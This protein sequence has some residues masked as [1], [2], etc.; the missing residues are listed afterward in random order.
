MGIVDRRL[1]VITGKGGVGRST[2]T[3][4]LGLAAARR[5][6]RVALV[7]L[8]RQ[9][10]LPRM[11]AMG[12]RTYEPRRVAP[13]VDLLGLSTLDCL[14]DFGRRKLGLRN[15]AKWFFESSLMK[16]FVTAVPGLPDVIQLGKIE[17]MITQPLKNESAYDLVIVDGPA[18]GQGLTLLDSARA[19][20]DVTR[21]GPFYDLA[22]R[23]ADFLSD[24][25]QTATLAVTLPESL[26][27]SETLQLDQ[28]MR[29][30][31]HQLHGVLLNRWPR[32]HLPST[33]T[34]DA[35]AASLDAATGLSADG[36]ASLRTLATRHLAHLDAA[37]QVRE[38]LAEGLASGLPIVD[39]PLLTS[40][41]LGVQAFEPLVD[42]LSEV[43]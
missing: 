6:K 39:L 24:P 7:E 3:I 23:I 41:P 43:P 2:A 15:V 18:T 36:A 5:G 22:L 33:A 25:R 9:S 32:R 12:E 21:V 26:P 35:V 29:Q 1:V 4:A 30:E 13:G 28:A 34:P 42:A 16:G 20:A 27:V 11:L 31:G 8:S 10:T 17:D 14:A 40:A 38:R 19:M 37:V